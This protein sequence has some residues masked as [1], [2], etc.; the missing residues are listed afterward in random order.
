MQPER[1]RPVAF[2]DGYGPGVDIFCLGSRIDVDLEIVTQVT[3]GG[4]AVHLLDASP[5]GVIS[6]R[7]AVNVRGEP[8]SVP[9]NRMARARGR[10]AIVIVDV[11]IR[12][13]R[14]DRVWPYRARAG[15]WIAIARRCAA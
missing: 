4:C 3:G 6:E 10:V 12:P 5:I 2:G 15:G 8:T 11:S 14:G 7:R 1:G 9:R 13:H